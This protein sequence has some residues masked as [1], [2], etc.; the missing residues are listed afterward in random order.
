MFTLRRCAAASSDLTKASV[1]LA[2]ANKEHKM[3]VL[4]AEKNDHDNMHKVYRFRHNTFIDPRRQSA[5]QRH[6][7][8]CLDCRRI[9]QD[10]VVSNEQSAT[11]IE[12]GAKPQQLARTFILALLKQSSSST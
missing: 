4:S 8:N 3:S 2:Y 5:K 1:A 10:K 9:L 7:A 12:K 11:Q 6:T